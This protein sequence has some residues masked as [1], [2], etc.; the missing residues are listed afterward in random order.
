[1]RSTFTPIKSLFFFFFFIIRFDQPTIC[2][3]DNFKL[4]ERFWIFIRILTA[5]QR[6][7]KRVRRASNRVEKEIEKKKLSRE[8][9]KR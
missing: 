1:M 8:Q 7:Y 5:Y 6:P 3:K 2:C 4:I 9:F